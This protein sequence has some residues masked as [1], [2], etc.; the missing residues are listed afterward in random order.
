VRQV[1][2]G[3]G[4][5]EPGQKELV[6]EI[7]N[8]LD[9]GQVGT[10]NLRGFPAREHF[11]LRIGSAEKNRAG[12]THTHFGISDRGCIDPDNPFEVTDLRWNSRINLPGWICI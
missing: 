6:G 7:D 11:D 2:V 8:V 10:I 12:C 5:D 9:R 3:V 4:V 1:E